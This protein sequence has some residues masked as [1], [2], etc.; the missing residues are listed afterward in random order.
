MPR[1]MRTMR[2]LSLKHD[3]DLARVLPVAGRVTLGERGRLDRAKI[4]QTAFGLADDLVRHDEDVAG[5][6]VAGY[7]VRDHTVQIVAGTDFGEALDA[8]HLQPLHGR[9]APALLEARQVSRRVEVEGQVGPSQ[10]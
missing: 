3:L 10:T 9:A 4:D 2:R 7:C 1:S 5:A 6:Q 8:E